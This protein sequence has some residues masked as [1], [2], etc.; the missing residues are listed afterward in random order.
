MA[1][2]SFVYFDLD[3]TLLDHRRAERLALG[4]LHEFYLT[5]FG[6]LNLTS[7][8]D[9]YHEVNTDVWHRYGDGLISKERAKPERFELLLERLL[10]DGRALAADLSTYY[11]SRY[12]E[13]WSFVPGG[14]DAFL[15]IADSFQVGILTNGFTEVQNDK[16]ARFPEIKRASSTI[17][18]S[19]DVGFMKP[20]PRIFDHAAALANCSPADILYIGDSY[21]SDVTGGKVAGWNVAW[22]SPGGENGKPER[23][24]RAWPEIL[25][26]M[27]LPSE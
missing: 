20:D 2:Y 13:H 4:N 6:G 16:L 22:F 12:A 18:I 3:D 7:V 9:T 5:L 21:R 19:E 8:Q 27:D 24:F 15:T 26:W 11:M 25:A 14:R 17:V 23:C 1:D 10:I